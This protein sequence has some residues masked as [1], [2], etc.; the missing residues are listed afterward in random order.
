MEATW[1]RHLDPG[2]TLAVD[3]GSMPAAAHGGPRRLPFTGWGARRLGASFAAAILAGLMVGSSVFAA[4]RAGGPL[5]ES[6]LA[7]ESLALPADADARVDAQIGRAEAR[8]GE[9]VEAAFRHDDRA[10]AAALDAYDRAIDDLATSSGLAATEALEAV[11]FHRSVLLQIAAQSADD[12]A[13]GIDRALANSTKVITRLAE[14]EGG[15][16]AGGVNG[17]PQGQGNGAGGVNGDPQGNGAGGVNGDPQG[18]G[19]NPQGT[20]APTPAARTPVP[21][22]TAEPTSR[23]TPKPTPDPTTRPAGGPE[24]SQDPGRTPKPHKTPDPN[25]G[26]APT[27]GEGGGGADSP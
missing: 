8:L 27:G 5:Y 1:R 25:G 13:S 10:T 23:P 20:G 3:A 12:N 24:P 26:G 9:A 14:R 17:A 15:N 4:S 19:G 11:G 7:L 21:Q 18:P 22:A 2:A 16:G 6:R